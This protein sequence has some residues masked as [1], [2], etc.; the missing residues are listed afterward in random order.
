MFNLQYI[1]MNEICNILRIYKLNQ[2][3]SVTDREIIS[4]KGAEPVTVYPDNL[5][6][7]LSPEKSDGGLLYKID[8]TVPISKLPE[9]KAMLFPVPIPAIIEGETTTGKKIIIGTPEFPASVYIVPNLQKDQLSI[10]CFMT[11]SPF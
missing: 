10:V 8:Q 11:K 3:R 9:D 6:L 2:L 1:T 7:D 4:Q 5:E